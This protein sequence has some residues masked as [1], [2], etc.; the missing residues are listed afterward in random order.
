M[1]PRRSNLQE[2]R[3]TIVGV[4]ATLEEAMRV[5]DEAALR[6][7]L[8]VDDEMHLQGIMTD[9]DMRR[10]ILSHQPLSTPVRN[11]MNRFPK[12]ASIDAEI[13]AR[14][15]FVERHAHHVPLVDKDGKLV[16]LETY[17][18]LLARPLKDNWVFLMAGGF[19]R[20]LGELTLNCPKPMLRVGGKPILETI[21]ENFILAGFNKFYISVHYLPDIIKAHFGDGSS[22]GVTIRYVE[23]TEPLGTAGAL[24]LIPETDG[25]PIIMMNGD[26]LAKLD[27]EKLMDDHDDR[28][29]DITVCTREYEVQIPFGVV[30]HSGHEVTG[31]VEK[32]VQKYAVNAG[33]YVVAPEIVSI[34]RPVRRRDMPDLIIDSIAGNRKVSMFSI[35]DYWIDVGR[36][37]DF[38]RAQLDIVR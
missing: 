13:D 6:I 28:S 21:I 24:G 4:E 10:V 36:P 26:I 14:R 37:D 38:A 15:L 19:G 1:S 11:V 8:I 5:L 22:R 32:P 29:A 2:W 12:T 25:L 23:E 31:I 17:F 34:C 16:G 20:R 18:D 9:G 30:V 3:K 33:V 7:V 35:S 27:Y